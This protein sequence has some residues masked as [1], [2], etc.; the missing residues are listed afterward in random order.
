M[1]RTSLLS[2]SGQFKPVL[3][4]KVSKNDDKEHCFLSW[5]DV[6]SRTLN[7]K[8]NWGNLNSTSFIKFI[9]DVDS[10][11]NQEIL[12]FRKTN[13]F[14]WSHP[15]GWRYY[16]SVHHMF[17]RIMNCIVFYDNMAFMIK[18][19]EAHKIWKN[20]PR[21]FDKSADLLRLFF[22]IIC[23]S[24]KVRFAKHVLSGLNICKRSDS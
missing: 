12:E 17:S 2:T 13:W 1:H 3:L 14:C 10:T 16:V 6:V 18:F 7:L 21:G 19:G 8:K 24:Q 22:Q 23:A 5:F 9:S 4:P 15:V 20:L 11:G